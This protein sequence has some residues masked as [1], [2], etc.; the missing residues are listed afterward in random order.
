MVIVLHGIIQM[1]DPISR[2]LW[3]QMELLLIKGD[4]EGID[5]NSEIGDR[6]F[7]RKMQLLK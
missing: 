7:K 6:S 4:V 3:M 1:D 5:R 2:Q